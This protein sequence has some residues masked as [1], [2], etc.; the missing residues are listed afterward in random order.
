MLHLVS[1]KGQNKCVRV[2][3]RVHGSR[4]ALG[5]QTKGFHRRELQFI[6][7]YIYIG[8]YIFHKVDAFTSFGSSYFFKLNY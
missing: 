6:Y 4:Y 7:I 2:A 1:V 3:T 8:I 5:I